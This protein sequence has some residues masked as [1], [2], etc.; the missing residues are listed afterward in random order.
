MSHIMRRDIVTSMN[1][2]PEV[3]MQEVMVTPTGVEV[4]P[5]QHAGRANPKYSFVAGS[6]RLI[7]AQLRDQT[8]FNAELVQE[9]EWLLHP[10][11][12][13]IKL[14]GNVFVL[15]N[16][17]DGCGIIFVKLAP[18]PGSRAIPSDWDFRIQRNGPI[19]WNEGDGYEWRQ[20]TYQGGKWNRIE[21]LHAMQ[22]EMRPYNPTRDGLLLTNTWGDRNRDAH[23]NSTF[24]AREIECAARL[25]ADVVQIDDGWQQGVTA[26]S[27]KAA[28]NGAWDG[29]WKNDDRFWD[30][31]RERFPAGLEPL[32]AQARE[33][34]IRVGL[35]FAPDGSNEAANWERDAELLLRYHRELG[36]DFFKVDALKITTPQSEENLR[37]LF[38]TVVRESGGAVSFDFDITAEHRFGYF[39]LIEPGPLFVEN[40]YTDWH[41]YW[42]HYTLRVAWQLAHW[43]DPLRLRLEWLNNARH[44]ELYQNDPLAPANYRPDALFATVMMCS[45]LGWFENQNLPEAYF[46]EASPLIATWKQHRETMQAGTILPIWLAPDGYAWTGFVSI[47]PDRASGYALLFR[48]LNPSAKAELQLP[49][50]AEVSGTVEVLGG[51][52]TAS[53]QDGVL[54]VHIPE[55]LRYLWIRFVVFRP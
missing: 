46:E 52:G 33:R 20:V 12:T 41:S 17:F 9:S 29:F 11:N 15:E 8:D 37:R 7:S 16:V 55:T 30:V 26:N 34:Q 45:P 39:G 35:W 18:L 47:A 32:F 14:Q 23:L 13:G 31:N 27:F 1:P 51:D 44:S 54:Q 48:E 5:A 50:L 25:G 6:T 4:E 40:R 28:G 10:S 42:P 24:M 53:L 38:G 3:V 43:I 21:A 22:R 2:V 36:V 19:E 49:L